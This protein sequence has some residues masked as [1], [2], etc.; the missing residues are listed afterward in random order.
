MLADMDETSLCREGQFDN[1]DIWQ[2]NFGT[3]SIVLW[4]VQDTRCIDMSVFL[5]KMKTDCCII[6]IVIKKGEIC[7]KK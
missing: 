1:I 3:I 5:A 2:V 7:E 4:L 6:G